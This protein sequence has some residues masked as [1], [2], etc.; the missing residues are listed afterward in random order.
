MSIR[1]TPAALRL[2]RRG[3]GKL[4]ARVVATASNSANV[5]KTTDARGTLNLKR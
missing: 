1:L 4:R 2:L 5:T 3:G